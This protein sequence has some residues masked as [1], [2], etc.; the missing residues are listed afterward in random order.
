MP[1]N[2]ERGK[3]RAI[4]FAVRMSNSYPWPIDIAVLEFISNKEYMVAKRSSSIKRFGSDVYISGYPIS[5]DGEFVIR[6][7]QG[8]VDLP[9][10]SFYQTCK[11]YGLRYIAQ[12]EIGMDGG[13]VWSKKG[14]L[15]GIHGYREVSRSDNIV[16]NRGSYSTGIHLPYW[17]ELVDPFNPSRGFPEKLE[18]YD[19]K[20]DA[21]AII[22][23]AKAFINVARSENINDNSNLII[24]EASSSI[25]EDLKRAEKI[26]S[27]R[28]LIPALTAQIYIRRYEDGSKQKIYLTE[29]LQNINKAIL[30]QKPNWLG[31]KASYVGVLR[32]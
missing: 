9:P 13:G 11:G 3:R 10:S 8:T 27:K 19:R 24:E 18:K 32:R 17:K 23:K 28:P 16:I 25:L 14:K 7:S 21:S 31:P 2:F 20:D 29:A 22:S 1:P 30:L 6:E 26:D 12:T 15:V 4:H 5:R